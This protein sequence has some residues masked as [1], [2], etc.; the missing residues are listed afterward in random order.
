M[1]A[2]PPLK[3]LPDHK[4]FRDIFCHFEKI[5]PYFLDRIQKPDQGFFGKAG[6]TATECL[7][8][9]GYLKALLED[10]NILLAGV[11]RLHVFCKEWFHPISGDPLKPAETPAKLL[12]ANVGDEVSQRRFESIDTLSK[13][14]RSVATNTPVLPEPPSLQAKYAANLKLFF[15]HL[16]RQTQEGGACKRDRILNFFNDNMKEKKGELKIASLREKVRNYLMN[17]DEM[18]ETNIGIKA[19]SDFSL[20][21]ELLGIILP[22][23][24]K[25]R[26]INLDELRSLAGTAAIRGTQ[27]H[28][29]LLSKAAEK[30][31]DLTSDAF[32]GFVFPREGLGGV[33]A[34]Y[35][36]ASGAGGAA[37]PPG[38]TMPGGKGQGGGRRRHRRT[39][40]RSKKTTRRDKSRR[41][42]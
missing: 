17:Y 2:P 12:I 27:I 9:L 1:A 20:V 11:P 15:D 29:E 16:E 22:E 35:R 41:H 28:A 42:H 23:F 30:W 10:R 8:T 19:D 36:G 4:A 38:F 33:S 39:H 5:L 32:L 26:K 6:D 37:Y 14:F 40:R 21:A 24:V 34:V 25:K 7:Q 18:I 3:V 13:L 31:G